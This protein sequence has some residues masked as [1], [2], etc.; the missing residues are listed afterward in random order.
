MMKKNIDIER[1][2]AITETALEDIPALLDGAGIEFND[3]A[4][5]NWNWSD[6]NPK[7]QFRVAHCGD[8]LAIHFHVSDN[9]L[10]AVEHVNDGRV[11]EDSCCEFFVSPDKD[12]FYY[13]FECNCIGTLLLHGGR[14]G[15]RPNASDEVYA[16][17]KRWSSLGKEPFE[18]REQVCEWDLVE[19]IPAAA[20]FRHDIKDFSGLEMAAN[21]YN[22]GDLLPHSHYLSWAP[23][24]FEKPA[25][26]MPQF[27]GTIRFK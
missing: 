16:S 2:A 4:C 12:D 13:N 17:V 5:D 19:I 22:C 20:L 14:K 24:V 26:H 23:I 27:F 1:I 11:W 6:R 9:E 15:D 7:V 8:A 10:R 25:F 3:I 21:F 18:A